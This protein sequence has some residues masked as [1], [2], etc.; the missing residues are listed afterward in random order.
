MLEISDIMPYIIFFLSIGLASLGLRAGLSEKPFISI[1]L[2]ISSG[3]IAFFLLDGIPM[4]FA[5]SFALLSMGPAMNLRDSLKNPLSCIHGEGPFL[6][7]FVLILLL[8][9]IGFHAVVPVVQ[10]IEKDTSYEA[11]FP[12]NDP[13]LK[14]ILYVESQGFG[15]LSPISIVITG[16]IMDTEAWNY[17][18]D[19]EKRLK[20]NIDGEYIINVV[21]IIDV[22]YPNGEIPNS[23]SE[24]RNDVD[25]ISKDARELFLS[26]D[27]KTTIIYVTTRVGDTPESSEE[28]KKRIEDNI[29]KV[30]KPVQLDVSITGVPLMSQ[31]LGQLI[32]SSQVIVAI[33]SIGFLVFYLS[34]HAVRRGRTYPKSSIAI[35]ILLPLSFAILGTFDI[36]YLQHQAINIT[37][38]ILL[39]LIFG[40][41]IDDTLHLLKR[42]RDITEE[43]RWIEPEDAIKEA[44]AQTGGAAFATTATTVIALSILSLAPI[45][46]LQKFAPIGCIGMVLTLVDSMIIFPYLIKIDYY[47]PGLL[48]GVVCVLSIIALIAIFLFPLPF[49]TDFRL[50]SFLVVGI[51]IAVSFAELIGE[52]G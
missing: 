46:I 4:I 12:S 5:L 17:I 10:S 49:I 31:R 1:I 19:V 34:F 32:S 44:I 45:P 27:S 24:L 6:S 29:N 50:Y 28:L 3:I 7:I 20:E 36:I 18:W 2:G 15:S 47:Y 38:P 39:T 41:G 42:F 11:M 22:V 51:I 16:K 43:R 33:L 13:L 52:Y 48:S 14:D 25:N 23:L 8:A 9:F 26:G 21:G 35:S 40:I 37:I 30:N